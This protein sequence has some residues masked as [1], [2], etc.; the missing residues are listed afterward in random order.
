MVE[1]IFKD[2]GMVAKE[3]QTIDVMKKES[4]LIQDLTKIVD[5]ESSKQVETSSN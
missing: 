1:T 2:E 5:R 4:E 3:E